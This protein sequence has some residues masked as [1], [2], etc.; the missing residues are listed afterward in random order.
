MVCRDEGVHQ[1]L[2]FGRV[3]NAVKCG[4]DLLTV[5]QF[6]D[7]SN[8]SSSVS[9]ISYIRQMRQTLTAVMSAMPRGEGEP[10]SGIQHSP[11]IYG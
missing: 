7:L 9:P 2:L 5:I 8:L 6:S 4:V 10:M 3:G 1:R 11:P